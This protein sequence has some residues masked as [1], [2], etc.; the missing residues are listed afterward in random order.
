[1]LAMPRRNAGPRR[2]TSKGKKIGWMG[3]VRARARA[4]EQRV[5]KRESPA[6][7]SCWLPQSFDFL[8]PLRPSSSSRPSRPCPPLAGP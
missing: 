3:G 5:A 7:S 6:I 1:M 2:H 8:G 4:R